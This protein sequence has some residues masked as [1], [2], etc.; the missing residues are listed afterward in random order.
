MRGIEV[1]QNIR[2]NPIDP[3]RENG[4]IYPNHSKPIDIDMYLLQSSMLARRDKK[5]LN[6]GFWL[7][8]VIWL[9]FLGYVFYI[10]R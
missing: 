7:F 4:R 3:A 10:T 6:I 2:I 8:L 1:K 9:A 5:R